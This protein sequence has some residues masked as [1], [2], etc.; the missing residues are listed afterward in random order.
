MS[1]Q[2]RPPLRAGWRGLRF[3]RHLPREAVHK[4]ADAEVLLTDSARLGEERFAV[5]ALWDRDHHLGHR[6]APAADPLLLAETVRQSAIHLAHRFH[7]STYGHPFVLNGL[8]VE[9][10]RPLPPAGPDGLDVG[11]DLDCRALAARRPSPGRERFLLEGVAWAGQRPVGRVRLGWEVLAPERYAVLR[12][13]SAAGA[14]DPEPQ[15]PALLPPD[16]AR[17]GQARDVLLAADPER[18]DRW[19]LRPFEHHPVLYDH[20]VDHVP[21]MVLLEAFR[22]AAALTALTAL[23]GGGRAAGDGAADR[24]PRTLHVDFLAFGEPGSP[25]AV[26]AEPDPV[27]APGPAPGPVPGFAPGAE[28]TVRLR[29]V[30]DGR[31]IAEARLRCA[32]GPVPGFAPGAEAGR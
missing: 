21:G 13:R 27:P 23:A 17:A 5:A 24:Q 30:Q 7:G 12:R 19:W 28:G 9:L 10:D 25:I 2:H 18:A 15:P 31:P 22:Q 8:A 11:L 6:D 20:A 14:G 32:A 16:T 1:A 4:A 26:L 29:A 3:D